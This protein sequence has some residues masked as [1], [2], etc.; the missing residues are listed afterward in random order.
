MG[1][2]MHQFIPGAAVSPSEVLPHDPEAIPLSFVQRLL[3]TTDGTVTQVLEAYA[4][5]PILVVKLAQARE[6]WNG[7][8][9]QLQL[10]NGDM[11]LRRSVLL[12]GRHSERNFVYAESV[13][14]DRL[15]AGLLHELM[16]GDRPIGKL[17]GE[18]RVEAFREVV[19]WGQEPAGECSRYFGIGPDE[20]VL[21]RSYRVLSCGRPVMMITE[22][23][24]ASAFQA[25][26][27]PATKG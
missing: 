14:T 11:V 26:P 9:G 21:W 15:A 17:L 5:E 19:A 1:P 8:H 4:G 20:P 13:I 23:F 6:P 22:K 24:P 25:L 27:D 12:Q 3:L 16:E 18:H 7:D 10:G 2:A